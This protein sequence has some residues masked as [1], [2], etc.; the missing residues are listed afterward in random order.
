[1]STEVHSQIQGKAPLDVAIIG[2]GVSGAYTAYRLSRPDLYH[3]RRFRERLSTGEKAMPSLGLFELQNRSGGRLWSHRFPDSHMLAE[4]G[5]Q[6]FS[7]LQANVFGLCNTELGLTSEACNSYNR[8]LFSYLRRTRI[9]DSSSEPLESVSSR[10]TRP[11]TLPYFLTSQENHRALETL[12]LNAL[13]Q[14]LPDSVKTL[15]TDFHEALY[16]KR[17]SESYVLRK[18]LSQVLRE[19]TIHCIEGDSHEKPL[20]QCGMWNILSDALSAEAYQFA[21]NS[22]YSLSIHRNMNLYDALMYQLILSSYYIHNPTPWYELK[23]GYQALPSALLENFQACGG[24]VFNN[25]ELVDV[26]PIVEKGEQLIQL[27]FMGPEKDYEQVTARQVVL[28]LPQQA[29]LSLAKS[30][31]LLNTAPVLSALEAVVPVP[32]S[33][34]FLVYDEPWWNTSPALKTMKGPSEQDIAGFVTTDL[35]LRVSYYN[36]NGQEGKYLLLASICDDM[37]PSFWQGYVDDRNLIGSSQ[38][39]NTA[40]NSPARFVV[41]REMIAAAQKQLKEVHGLA[42]IPDPTD[43]VFFNWSCKPFGGGWHQ[44]KPYHCSWEVMRRVRRPVP[45]VDVYV[46]GE[47]FSALQGWVEGALNSAEM[48]LED[49]LGLSHPDWVDSEYDMGP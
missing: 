27:T 16:T 22:S 13:I 20:Y 3:N 21:T 5:G 9:F 42:H 29:L 14:R 6:G 26:H 45:D 12:I 1:M 24:A 39:L 23:D 40:S 8:K 43:S 15:I 31:S 7:E 36:N 46:C 32:A 4:I 17:V 34:F 48:V 18:T 49:Y 37:M 19:T 44:W 41:P 33:K 28:A 38:S 10:T 35:P 25:K 30:S 47:A 11:A 2:G